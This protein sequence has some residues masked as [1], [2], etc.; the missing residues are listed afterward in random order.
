MD[1]NK[2]VND[3]P[4][5]KYRA[6]TAKDYFVDLLGKS[7]VVRETKQKAILE[8]VENTRVSYGIIKGHTYFDEETGILA[9]RSK[10]S[11]LNYSV[12]LLK[13]KYIRRHRPVYYGSETDL[14]KAGWK[15]FKLPEKKLYFVH[16]C[17]EN[18]GFYVVSTSNAKARY[19][20]W[21]ELDCNF[22]DV[23]AHI[24]VKDSKEL[25]K[26]GEGHVFYIDDSKELK[27][28]GVE[29]YEEY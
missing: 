25:A 28:L 9:F 23:R 13:V 24:V 7:A 8:F 19:R 3:F 20:V 17:Y 26:Y 2:L 14:K 4:E 21:G 11:P 18:S 12:L 10:E 1:L 29:Y 22:T 16:T 15:P 6:N 5:N 27:K